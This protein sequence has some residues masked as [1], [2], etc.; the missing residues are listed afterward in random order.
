MNEVLEMLDQFIESLGKRAQKG[1]FY[2]AGGE[3]GENRRGFGENNPLKAKGLPALSV[4]SAP[5][6]DA[7]PS[8]SSAQARG[9]GRGEEGSRLVYI[10][11]DKTEKAEKAAETL[12]KLTQNFPRYSPLGGETRESCKQQSLAWGAAQNRWHLEHGERVPPD[13][14]AGCRQPIGGAEALDLIDGNRVHLSDGYNCLIRHGERWRAA[15]T[16]A[17]AELGLKP[18]SIGL[19]SRWTWSQAAGDDE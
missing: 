10:Q 9:Q 7:R 16:R 11:T 18:T 12:A 8:N 15:A 2:P 5:Q 1:D 3:N 14:C 17:L 6:Q 4:F 19:A 13:L